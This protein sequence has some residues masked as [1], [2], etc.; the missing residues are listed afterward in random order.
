MTDPNRSNEGSGSFARHAAQLVQ[1]GYQVVPIPLGTK[2]PVIKDWLNKWPRT[3]ADAVAMAR[4]HRT[5][6]VGIIARETP[7]I[8]LDI[9]DAGIVRKL[10]AFVADNCGE[11]L[12]RIGKAPKALIMFGTDRPF[13]KVTSASFIDPKNPTKANGKP[14]HQRV[15]VL[16][17]GQQFVAYHVHPE[18]GRPYAWIE[19]GE[20]PLAIGVLDLPSIGEDHA[21]A[22]C[23]FYEK[24]ATEA[25]WTK[26]EDAHEGMNGHEVELLAA[27][28]PP[29]ETEY[30]IARA[31]RALE[32]ISPDCSRPEYLQVLAALKN[33]GWLC[34]EEL[35]QEWAQGSKEDK[36]NE[37]DFHRDW[38][39]FKQE[40]NGK[41]TVRYNTLIELAKQGGFDA[42][43][44]VDPEVAD[45]NFET[46]VA[47][48]EALDPEDRAARKLLFSEI[49]ATKFD[50]VDLGEL[51]KLLSKKLKMP[52]RE[53]K[54]YLHEA[55]SAQREHGD[56][57]HANYA[58][59][60]IKKLEEETGQTPIGCY[61]EV[62]IYDGD[63]GIWRGKSPT[64][65]ET[66]VARAFDGLENCSRRNDYLAIANHLYSI[67]EAGNENF[68]ADAPV[69]LACAGRFYHVEENEIKREPLA[70]HHRQRSISD[71]V[72]R[73]ME[74]PLW[75]KLM[76][77]TFDGDENREQE[78]LLEE[79]IG[80]AVIGSVS[81]FEK[82]L[83]MKGVGRAGKGTI[84]KIIA[85]M[86][87]PK[88]IGA[89]EPE[90]WSR[91]YYL[92]DL[93][94]R[95]INIV[96]E[97]SDEHAIDGAAFKR[98]TGRDQLSARNPAGRPFNFVCTAGHIFNSNYF[99]PTK[100]HT[101]AFF[102]RWLL[103]EFR[104]SLIGRDS[105][106]DKD[107]AQKIIDNELPGVCARMLKG[108]QRLMARN[109][110]V[111]TPQHQKLMAA[112][113]HRSNS[114]LEFIN[115]EDTCVI[116]SFPHIE[117]ACGTF[118]QAYKTWCMDSGRKALGKNKFYEECETS[119]VRNF[120]IKFVRKLGNSRTVRGIALRNQVFGNLDDMDDEL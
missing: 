58:K 26:A 104:N 79:Y 38:N 78:L 112:W 86:V 62:W 42:S 90:K 33:T 53:V 35:A 37:R 66:Q 24:L 13:T 41:R 111:E 32:H 82:A 73:V 55:R 116:G 17:D 63:T 87:P 49:T 14:L 101:D 89:V 105:E 69:G 25:G 7:A 16:G 47:R 56:P 65:F 45:E 50:G 20:D 9:L 70:A 36:Y 77:A 72:P 52:V 31:K 115:D 96:G 113:R 28:P 91:E 40:R 43:R 103:I 54:S 117:L 83:L 71:V 57:T 80:A 27:A 5:D 22:V 95:R 21:Q 34:A 119:Q 68:F 110:F 1:Q 118:Y 76:A 99:V 30:E 6:G 102:A 75:D 39:S 3:P 114:I 94:G 120:G 46:F 15:E 60:L 48:I 4:R 59:A 108:A 100:D 64:Q 97:L 93:A 88:D 109:A 81:K 84:L 98:V 74:T 12:L 29:D 2:G 92:A 51:V 8:D 61:G 23:R 67:V 10:L 11:G 85:A 106:I 19:P 44:Q 18:T 107:L